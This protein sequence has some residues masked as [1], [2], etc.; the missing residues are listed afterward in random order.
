MAS[1]T[2]DRRTELSQADIGFILCAARDAAYD[3]DHMEGAFELAAGSPA[4]GMVRAIPDHLLTKARRVR[5]DGGATLFRSGEKVRCVFLALSGEVRLGRIGRGGTEITLQRARCGFIA[6][7]SLD[8]RA[9]HCNAVASE[10]TDLLVFPAQDFKA[11][12]ESDLAFS[13]LWQSLLA[14]EVRK[15][16]AQCERM[17]LKTAEERITHYIE[18]EGK[19]GVVVLPMNKKSW[20]TDLGLTHEALYRALRRMDLAGTLRIEGPRVELR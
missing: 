1:R 11:A 15:L 7:A 19:D 18:A 20:A 8:S 10:V 9:Y 3:S 6:E 13:R 14:N 16:R 4:R 17:G 2:K 5:L 12:L